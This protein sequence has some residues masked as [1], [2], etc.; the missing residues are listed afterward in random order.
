VSQEV[1]QFMRET[2][3]YAPPVRRADGSMVDV[4]AAREHALRQATARGRDEANGG[5]PRPYKH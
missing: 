1:R 5:K 2:R 3:A 4:Y